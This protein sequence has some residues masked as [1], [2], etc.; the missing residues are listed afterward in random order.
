MTIPDGIP[1]VIPER[2]LA[3][4]T[5]NLWRLALVIG[6]G[7]FAMS[8]WSWQFGIYIETIIEPWQMGLTFSA[9]SIAG[10]IGV[11]LSGYVSD[12]IGRRKTLLIAYIPMAVGLFLL[13]AYPIWPFLPFF[14]G[15]A[16]F[17]WSFVVVMARAAPADQVSIDKGK[18]AAK[19][20]S[21]VLLPAFAVDGLSPLFASLLL[22][23]GF[24]QQNLLFLGAI[25]TILA[26][27]VSFVFVR[28]TLSDS[29]QERARKGSIIT[30]R[31]LGRDFWILA[32]G[33]IGVA[34]SFGMSFSYLGNL[35][36]L[37]WGVDTATWGIIWS[38]SSLC[39]AAF[40]Y[41]GGKLAD[42]N[43]KPA[44][45]LGIL[46]NIFVLG[47]FAFGSGIEVLVILNILW[48]FPI[49]VWLSSER[50]LIVQGVSEEMKGRAFGTY[51]VVISLV[52]IVAMNMGAWIWTAFGS[53]R[54]VFII[55]TGIMTITLVPLAI[56]LYKIK[57]KDNEVQEPV[58]SSE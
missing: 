34:F 12:F 5:A 39:I 17:G 14:Y 15:L 28:E 58:D 8:V 7:Q 48:A 3:G 52:Q 37:E 2:K 22:M 24:S 38:I 46:S 53:L 57:M 47:T 51:Q 40:S 11:P 23:T 31:G 41:Y 45:W 50:V 13:F 55:A 9:S 26:F 21:M 56:A 10:I 35:V 36:T 30:L 18:D 29:I 20:F 32:G 43:V 44:L 19:T 27:I 42:K 6:V 49:V 54:V 16:Q 4:L 33:I 1:D 25:G